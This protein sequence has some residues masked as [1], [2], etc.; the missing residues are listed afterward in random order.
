MEWAS[1]PAA[2]IT[3]HTAQLPFKVPKAIETDDDTSVMKFWVVKWSVASQHDITPRYGAIAESGN[4]P[5]TTPITDPPRMNIIAL[6][7]TVLQHATRNLLLHYTHTVV[8][9][10]SNHLTTITDAVFCSLLGTYKY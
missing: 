7:T 9:Y 1:R 2:Y 8:S 3:P 4:R 5:T 6:T 10:Y